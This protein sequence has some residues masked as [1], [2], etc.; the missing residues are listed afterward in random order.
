MDRPEP[1]SRRNGLA[2]KAPRS[3]QTRRSLLLSWREYRG[4]V[5]IPGTNFNKDRDKVFFF[6]AFEKD[7]QYVQDPVLDIRE[8]VTP[9]AGAVVAGSPTPNMRGGD[10]TDTSYMSSLN[11]SA[12]YA[13]TIPCVTVSGTNPNLCVPNSNGMINPAAIDPNGQVLINTLPLPNA[14]PAVTNGFNLVTAVTPFQP[15]DQEN[16]KIDFVISNSNRASIHYN[17]ES[18]TV[19]FPFGYFNNFTPNAYPTPQ[20]D[21]DASHSIVATLRLRFRQ[22]W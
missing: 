18:E 13:T 5:I 11:G 9:S 12:Y 20:I 21:H 10:F 8:T 17:H 7:L 3:A 14:N 4:P 2:R 22:L 6:A 1:C 19:P 16:I 15:R